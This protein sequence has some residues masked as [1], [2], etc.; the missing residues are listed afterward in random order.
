MPFEEL[1]AQMDLV[2]E[3]IPLRDKIQSLL[4]SNVLLEDKRYGTARAQLDSALSSIIAA[5]D[6]IGYTPR[7]QD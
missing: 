6:A 5:A 7:I 3:L 1:N 2:N 4:M